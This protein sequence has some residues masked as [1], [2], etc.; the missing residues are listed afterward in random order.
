MENVFKKLFKSKS[1]DEKTLAKLKIV[2]EK[3]VY[4][5]NSR[6]PTFVEYNTLRLKIQ[7]AK[8]NKQRTVR[9]NLSV[10]C[11]TEIVADGYYMTVIK[12]DENGHRHHIEW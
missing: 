2:N 9:T 1:L 7:L 3:V 6:I 12:P 11:F 10:A 8:N 5:P 4:D